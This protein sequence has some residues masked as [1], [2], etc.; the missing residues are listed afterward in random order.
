MPWE[1]P[2][3]LV[4]FWMQAGP[5]LVALI[6]VEPVYGSAGMNR[7]EPVGGLAKGTPSKSKVLVFR[8][9]VID[10][11]PELTVTSEALFVLVQS[12]D[13]SEEQLADT[14][15]RDDSEYARQLPATSR[16]RMRALE[17]ADDATHACAY[18]ATVPAKPA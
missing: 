9:P 16:P 14:I 5:R 12:V 18:D 7:N 1:P 2:A 11:C 13:S 15:D 8:V 6:V 4:V 17:P 10:S 3:L